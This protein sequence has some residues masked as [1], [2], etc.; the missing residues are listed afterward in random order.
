VV[1]F[2]VHTQNL[3]GNRMP[4]QIVESP[5]S[6]HQNTYPAVVAVPARNEAERIGACL[7][8]LRDQQRRPDAVV[9]LLNNCTDDTEAVARALAPGLGFDLHIVSRDLPAAQ[10]NAGCARRRAMRLAAGLAGPHGALLTTD[11]DAIVPADWVRRNLA[12]L[13]LGAD[14]VCGRV[15]VDPVEAMLIPAHLHADDALECRLI[16]LLDDLAWLLDP[17]PHDPP[18]RHTEA[19]GA[20]LAVSAA[21]YHRV[22]GIPAIS[23][24]EDRAFVAALWRMDA[25]VRH[26]PGI[27]VTVSGRIEGRAPGG[28]ADAI[29]R[30]MV[31]QDRFTDNQVE[32][33]AAA[34]LRYSLRAA[35]RQAWTAR[36]L[37]VA[38][39]DDLDIPVDVL[40]EA[41]PRPFFGAAWAAL[42]RASPRLAR[43]RVRF[44]DLRQ[45]VA[46]AEAIVRRLAP[47]A[48]A[49]QSA[50]AEPMAV[51]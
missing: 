17:E 38:L 1:L 36:Q 50:P 37:D 44:A 9:L 5:D 18:P 3:P 28:M 34:F 51:D 48:A 35:A 14:V 49:P 19:S 47:A 10:A 16:G 26:D 15:E 8:A 13:D 46:Q 40:A 22:G 21:A 30:R 33:A 29:R 39:A 27:T 32:S 20:S 45:E 24:G 43:R 23:A 6:A 31:R 12:A 11:A 42:E 41:L 7:A 4:D 25:R 2:A